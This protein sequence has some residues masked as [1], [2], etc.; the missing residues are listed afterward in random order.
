M[1]QQ[2]Q[3]ERAAH[4]RTLHDRRQVLLLPNAWDAASACL[5][6]DLGFAAIATT[7][8]GVAWSLGYPTASR[9]PGR[10]SSRRRGASCARQHY[11]SAPTSRRATARRLRRWARACAR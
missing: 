6:A 4:F 10:R 8:G 3:I 11:R 7:S 9:R 5:F 2:A 1:D